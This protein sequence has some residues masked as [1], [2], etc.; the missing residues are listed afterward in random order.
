MSS[1][2]SLQTMTQ[3]IMSYQHPPLQQVQK[4][5][6]LVF[7]GISFIEFAS[8]T[9]NELLFSHTHAFPNQEGLIRTLLTG[10][11][12]KRFALQR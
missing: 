11:M 3:G 2:K 8:L 6:N 4:K 1:L 5:P 12:Q 10:K 7:P 9:H